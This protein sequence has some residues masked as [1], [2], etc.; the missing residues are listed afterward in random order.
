MEH[1]W[2]M[3]EIQALH[4]L[5][6]RSPL[7][8]WTDSEKAAVDCAAGPEHRDLSKNIFYKSLDGKWRFR[9]LSRPEEVESNPEIR[10]WIHSSFDDEKWDDIIVPGTW[11]RQGYDK[12][13]YTNVQMPFENIPPKVPSENP[14]GLYRL[15]FSIPEGW[16]GRRVVLHIGSAESVCLVWVNGRAVGVFKDT[17]LPSEFDITDFL[18]EPGS[19]G[20]NIIA[21]MV[22]RYSDA[23]FV[24]DQDQWWFGGIHRSV[25]L[26]STENM[27]IEDVEAVPDLVSRDGVSEDESACDGSAEGACGMG[28]AAG[29]SFCA[30]LPLKIRMGIEEEFPGDKKCSVSWKLYPVENSEDMTNSSLLPPV[31]EGSEELACNIRKNLNEIRTKIKVENP[32][33]WS[34]ESPDRYVLA[35]ELHEESAEGRLLEA[36][37]FCTAFRSVRIKERQLLINDKLV[38]IKGANRHEHDEVTGKTIKTEAM[39]K[40]IR[41]LKE[42]NFNAVRTCHYPDDER[43]YELCDKYGIYLVDEANIENHYY[44]DGLCRS[45]MYSYAY[46][47]RIQRMVRRDKNHPSIIMWSLGNESGHGWN[48]EMMYAWCHSFDKTRPVH[49][50]G[51]TRKEYTQSGYSLESLARGRNVTDIVCPM[52]P[53]IPLVKEW[54]EK[55]AQAGEKRPFIMCEYSH[56]MGNSNGSLSDYWDLIRSHDGLQG[57]FIWDWIDQGLEAFDDK[58]VKYWKYGGD[59]G[60]SPTD[61]DFCLNGLLLPDQTPKPVM[62]ECFKVFQ[63]VELTGIDKEKGSV[64]VENRF[65]FTSLDCLDLVWRLEEDGLPFAEGKLTLPA[66]EAG[67][68]IEVELPFVQALE[69]RCRIACHGEI[70]LHVDFLYN[71]QFGL[72]QAGSS[73][74][75]SEFVL[76]QATKWTSPV[77]SDASGLLAAALCEKKRGE[78]EE[79]VFCSPLVPSVFRCPT[80]ND[81]QKTMPHDNRIGRSWVETFMDKTSWD[82]ESSVISA[83]GKEIGTCSAKW[84][85]GADDA[86]R[87]ILELDAEFVLGDSVAEYPKIGFTTRISS[88]YDTVRWYGKG[89]HESYN[90]RCAGSPLGCYSSSLHDM[91]TP[92]IVPQENGNRYG[93]RWLELSGAKTSLRIEAD[94]PFSFS[95]MHHEA[96]DLWKCFHTNELTDT[97]EQGYY[98]LNLDIAQRGVGTATCGPDTLEQYRIRPGNYKAKFRFIFG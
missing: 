56:A 7:L 98:I 94:R 13:H 93:V 83:G 30:E 6:S 55:A 48:Q 9:L 54:A 26:Y 46:M 14:T 10:D 18:L 8:P 97:T 76:R 50:E 35:L 80:E 23:S 84:S 47:I 77:G 58:G 38:Y 31:A 40:D 68:S 51:G 19:G 21:L 45:E 43:W 5:P 28:A 42:H 49:Y 17:R 52:Y 67:A 11:T 2:E 71:K 62:K 69:E 88:S 90:D 79:S 22:V 4:R 27:W 32:R 16:D 3:P 75:W 82:S 61:K 53:D 36:V 63:P 96:S 12:P 41:L 34:H 72:L 57:G 15:A 81:S 25:Y 70:V 20:S 37:A 39:V 64:T 65:D 86:G 92:Y 59:F 85:L 95:V 78:L 33:I 44:Y 74:G 1:I 73:A 29:E 24:E 89:G 66:A 91:E 60:D 87:N